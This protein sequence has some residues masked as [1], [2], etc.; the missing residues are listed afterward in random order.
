MTDVHVLHGDFAVPLD[1]HTH[2]ILMGGGGGGGG[3][4]MHEYL[5]YIHIIRFL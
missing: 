4:G 1:T 5:C 3:V 2:P